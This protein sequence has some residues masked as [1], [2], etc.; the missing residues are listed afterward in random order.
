MEQWSV[1][2]VG[3][4]LSSMLLQQHVQSFANNAISGAILLEVSL[5]DL[6]Y[7]DVTVLAHR[8]VILKGIEDLR[9]NKRVTKQ[10]FAPAASIQS[11]K[12][13]TMSSDDGNVGRVTPDK[14][15]TILVS[16]RIAY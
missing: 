7:M 1:E 4:W 13:Q 9:R 16:C 5:E 3:E 2:D 10:L 12:K 8:K 6:D 14:E 15:E 11:P